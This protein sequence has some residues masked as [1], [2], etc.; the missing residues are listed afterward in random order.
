[1]SSNRPRISSEIQNAKLS[2]FFREKPFVRAEHSKDMTHF[3]VPV[4][5]TRRRIVHGGI[6]S[7]Y[8]V[9]TVFLTDQNEIASGWF[10]NIKGVSGSCAK[11]RHCKLANFALN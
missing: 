1:M 7:R 6:L 8:V 2:E 3:T 5:T 10:N 4:I 11:T 9:N